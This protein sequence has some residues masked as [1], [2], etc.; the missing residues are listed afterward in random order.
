M[1]ALIEENEGGGS[2]NFGSI[3]AEVEGRFSVEITA[4]AADG[5]LQLEHGGFGSRN[6]FDVEAEI[7]ELGLQ[8]DWQ[9]TGMLTVATEPHQ[10]EWLEEAVKML[11]YQ[12]AY[13]ASARFISVVDKVLESLFNGI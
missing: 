8:V 2:L 5:K 6:G 10:I 13:Q 12:R 11:E 7:A 4:S 1:K 9:R 3:E